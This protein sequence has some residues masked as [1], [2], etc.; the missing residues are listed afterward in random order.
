MT[1]ALLLLFG[2][3]GTALLSAQDLVP[4]TFKAFPPEYELML[5]GDRQSYNLRGDGLRVYSLPTGAVRVT[6]IAGGSAPLGLNLDVKQGMAAVQAKLETRIGPLT[7]A[8]EAAT[9]KAP[10]SVTFSPDGKS[11]FVALL[12]EPGVD[13]YTVPGLKKVK[14]LVAPEGTQSGFTDV[15]TLGNELWAVQNDG[16]IHV[17]DATT[18]AYKDSK[19]LTGG[20]NAFLTDQGGGKVAVVNWDNG[21]MVSVDVSTRKPL[22]TLSTTASLRGFA[23]GQGTGF[24]TLFDR[25]QVAVID[26]ASW[27]VKASWAAGR[28]P[29]PVAFLGKQLFVGDM[30]SAQVLILDASTGKLLGSAAVP[31]NP[32]QMTASK[33]LVAVASR[34]RNNP[35]DYQQPGPEYGKVTLF[36]AKGAVVSSVWGRNQPT[37]LALS[38]DG[39]Y[40][41]FTD[42][43]DNNLE[44]YRINR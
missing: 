28:A 13:V 31:S 3:L 41:A 8:G 11:V 34:G 16:R 36:D 18:L 32:H 7:L 37:G 20:G 22:A 27:K 35:A 25:G 21:Q 19:D 4:V 6:L 14:R 26:G 29:R 2:F 38:A 42:Y 1:R 23:F 40:L 17:F 30:G 9:G 12:G 44:L 10:R 5:R 39:R 15:L 33:D 24:A 43:L